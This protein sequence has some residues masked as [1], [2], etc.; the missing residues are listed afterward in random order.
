MVPVAMKLSTTKEKRQKQNCLFR[1]GDYRNKGHNPE[2]PFWVR[3]QVK[4]ASIA[5][6][7]SKTEQRKQQD[8]LVR[9]GD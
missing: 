5:R 4:M 8:R 2:K 7:L 9:R 1:R 3:V 6:K